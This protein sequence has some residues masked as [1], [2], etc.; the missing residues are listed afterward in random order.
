MV[1]WDSIHTLI[2]YTH[3]SMFS[4]NTKISANYNKYTIQR[5]R[6][7][8]WQ[9]L[10]VMLK[11]KIKQRR[12]SLSQTTQ[13][14]GGDWGK[15]GTDRTENTQRPWFIFSAA[16]NHYRLF[17]HGNWMLLKR[18]SWCTMN[19]T[20]HSPCVTLTKPFYLCNEW[21]TYFTTAQF[22]PLL[23]L[24]RHVW[25]NYTSCTQEPTKPYL[26]WEW[27][28]RFHIFY[29]ISIWILARIWLWCFNV[30]V[31]SL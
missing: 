11:I 25:V 19:E 15:G 5:N 31:L 7:W 13:Y 22:V 26:Q 12:I 24:L 27:S 21:P 2:Y 6:R 30:C 3:I 23:H 1:T 14:K 29:H 8:C 16:K 20:S 17:K 4:F 10:E 18:K 9:A 28:L